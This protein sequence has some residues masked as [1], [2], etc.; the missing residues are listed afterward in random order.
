[1]VRQPPVEPG[2]L[3]PAQAPS[4]GRWPEADTLAAPPLR[5]DLPL[6]PLTSGSR[7]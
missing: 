1:M 7:P 4:L 3:L 6:R 5:P 2:S